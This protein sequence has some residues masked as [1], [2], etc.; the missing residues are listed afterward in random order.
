MTS[1]ESLQA[2]AERVKRETGHINLLVANAGMS[3][4]MLDK[5]RARHSLAE[6]VDYAWKTPMEE[7]SEVYNMN[8]TATYY[9]ILGKRLPAAQS[10]IYRSD[11][12]SR[13]TAF[14]NLLDE[15][16]KRG[17]PTKSQVIATASTASF[18]RNPRAGFAYCSSKA[19]VVSM[20]KSFATFCVPFGIRF[21]V[22]AAGRRSS[23][24][25]LVR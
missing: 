8:C 23:P 1:K 13:T 7:F 11:W 4:P 17:S 21:N 22:I 10:F 2:A 5:L 15:G 9:T 25:A 20:L 3:G 24:H 16:N 14:L 12:F 18:L 6:F 19:G